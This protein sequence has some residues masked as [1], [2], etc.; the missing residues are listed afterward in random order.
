[1]Y[2]PIDGFPRSPAQLP[3]DQSPVST[4]AVRDAAVPKGVNAQVQA[5]VD[6]IAAPDLTPAQRNAAY[7]AVQ[8]YY[9][10]AAS[11]GDFA[12]YDPDTLRATAVFAL[13]EAGIATRFRPEVVD[14][15]DRVIDSTNSSIGGVSLE[16]ATPAQVLEAY[17]T[18]QAGTAGLTGTTLDTRA[19]QLL[20]DADIPTVATTA[21]EYVEDALSGFDDM[22]DQA[23]IDALVEASER[24]EYMTA[25]MDADTAALI[26][27]QALG[28]IEER[29]D[30][31]QLAG[32]MVDQEW[33]PAWSA[34]ATVADRV[35]DTSRGDALL[36]R[37]GD[38][39]Y[40]SSGGPGNVSLLKPLSDEGKGLGLFLHM[41]EMADSRY[42]DG[43]SDILMREV[44]RA[45]DTYVDQ[46]VQPAINAYSEHTSELNWLLQNLGRGA[47][48][49]MLQKATQDYI[50]DHPGWQAEHDRLQAD[51]A[52]AG[53]MLLQQI[54]ALR[55][56]P[57]GLQDAHGDDATARIKSLLE[58]S[59]TGFAIATAAGTD[60]DA[61]G[62]LDLPDLIGFADTLGLADSGLGVVKSLASAHVQHNV[63]GSLAGLDPT[64]PVALADARAQIATLRDPTVATA[65]GLDPS[66][67]GDLDAAVDELQR[68]LPQNG[69]TLSQADVETRLARLDRRLNDLEAFD[70]SQPLGQVFRGIGVAAGVASLWGST[71]GFINDPSLESGIKLL[72]DTAGL[73]TAVGDL[74]TGLG[75]IPENSAWARF[76]ASAT[77]GKVLGTVGLGLGLVGVVDSL[78]EGDLAQAGIGAVGLGGGA[79]ALFG[80]ASW[81]G[82]VGVAIGFIAAAASFGLGLFR[83]NEAENKLED[84][85]EQFLRSLGYDAEAAEVLSDFSGDGYSSVSL[86]QQYAKEKGY[87]LADPADSAAFVDWINDLS[88]G[89]LT[90]LRDALNHVI[91]DYDGDATRLDSDTQEPPTEYDV[92]PSTGAATP[93]KTVGNPTT[94]GEIDAFLRQHGNYGGGSILP[95]RD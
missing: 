75:A 11:G 87:D 72:A 46:H 1:M 19:E 21:T 95:D 42:V 56:L 38:A 32:S 53:G 14:A 39:V 58:D 88:P 35:G 10:A 15:V 94:V 24:L 8:Q 60:P 18:V 7:E 23:R 69:E 90:D 71:T 43:A 80:S 48:P 93:R 40:D 41:A 51:V 49:E 47:T 44:N 59:E 5:A 6:D 16:G 17:E 74:A 45:L 86:L 34:L 62:G 76:S 52:D 85:S 83:A 73:S 26:T 89:A 66:Q 54:Q 36:T 30:D 2:R 9:D 77:L 61:V 81:A 64:D 55:D 37:I 65:L 67:L 50:D 12:G 22:D 78:S 29:M 4:S 63:L 79:L 28:P 13:T 92:N 57:P 20:R 82:P 27:E 3:R 25:G 70:K 84:A 68:T 33:A 91:D 31:V